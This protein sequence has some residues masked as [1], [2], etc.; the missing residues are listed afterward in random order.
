MHKS[1]HWGACYYDTPDER[2]PTVPYLDSKNPGMFGL[3][4]SIL[5][6]YKIYEQCNYASNGAY[7]RSVTR[8]CD[9]PNWIAD[10]KH[11]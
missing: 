6:R 9:Y 7:Y 1:D 10:E 5:G 11:Q 3:E 2:C 8:I 4:D